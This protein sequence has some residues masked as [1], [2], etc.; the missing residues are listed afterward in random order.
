MQRFRFW[1]LDAFTDGSSAGNPAGLVLL[2]AGQQIDEAAMQRLATEVATSGFVAE[3]AFATPRADGALALRYFSQEREVPFCGHATVAAAHHLLANSADFRGRSEL[4]LETRH[5]ILT[6]QN[7]IAT[8]G[9]VYIAA[10][11]PAFPDIRVTAD[12]AAQ[13][14]GIP[15]EQID[16]REFDEGS[17]RLPIAECG[18]KCVL[19]PVRMLSALLG[20]T[21]DYRTLRALV[22][23]K[24]LAAAV[25]YSRETQRAECDLRT[26]V[27]PPIFGYLEDMAT[28]SGNAAL[29]HWLRRTQRWTTDLLRIEQGP[30]RTNPNL[31][32][33]RAEPSGQL[34]IGGRAVARIDGHYLLH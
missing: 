11:E 17:D 29:G 28:G 25:L 18:Q 9:C 32:S 8:E 13:A 22:E 12:E 23:A 5:G 26:R 4:R 10:P 27:F 15:P 34:W 16:R 33:L 20:C 3:V 14:L 21:P 6:A 31:V 1:K 24:G 19:V 7:R 2:A 30:D